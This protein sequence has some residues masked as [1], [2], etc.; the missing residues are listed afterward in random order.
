MKTTF[1]ILL[2]VSIILLGYLCTMSIITPIQF[3][4]EKALRETAVI[5]RLIEIRKAQIEFKNKHGRYAGT[6]DSLI[7]FVN[8]AKIP[9]VA[10]EGLLSDFELEKGLTEKEALKIIKKGNSKEIIDRGL[11]AIDPRT[12]QL[13]ILFKRDTV[14][15]NVKDTLF[16]VDYVA[17]SL[18]YIPFSNGKVFELAT[19][20]L[21]TA[22]GF[23]IRVFECKT[24]FE[25]YLADLDK[26][27]VFNLV[28]NARKLDKYPGLQVGS[29]TEANNNAGNWE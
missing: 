22:S 1:R 8:T 6:F 5:K 14:Y 4:D 24:S 16:G 7:M 19:S 20:T 10:K 25:A 12:N 26:Q 2:A 29:L 15:T 23:P 18:R 17:D 13:V 3:D 11:G 27:M 21:R 9:M 28:E